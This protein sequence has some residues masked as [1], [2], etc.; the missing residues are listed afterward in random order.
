MSW[1]KPSEVRSADGTRLAVF[2]EEPKGPARADLLLIHGLADHMGRYPHVAEAFARAGYR[3]TGVDLRGNGL[4]DGKRGHV[5]SW[6]NYVDDVQAVV[7]TLPSTPIVVAHSM[8]GLVALDFVRQHPTPGLVLSA[9]LLR[10]QVAVP[11]WKKA[12]A[13]V[14]NRV[15]PSLAMGNELDANEVSRH[16]D[17]VRAYDTD[18]LVYHTATP[19]WYHEML[20]AGLRT[21]AAAPEMRVPLLCMWGTGEKIVDP[22]SIARLCSTWGGPIETHTWEGL[23]HEIFN[24]PERDQVLA[25]AT[26]WLNGRYGASSA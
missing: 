15:M 1:S 9:P 16:P 6:S 20:A 14:L 11:G 25:R 12:A 3:V 18:P 24:E 5:D 17:V 4:S 7:A 23:Y 10:P 26:A 2:R 13:R 8:G 19:R 22:D 21:T